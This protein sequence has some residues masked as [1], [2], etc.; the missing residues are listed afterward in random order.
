MLINLISQKFEPKA[1]PLHKNELINSYK[2]Y[3]RIL[4]IKRK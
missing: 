1:E 4:R 2:E 3:T